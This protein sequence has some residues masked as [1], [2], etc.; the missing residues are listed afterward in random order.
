MATILVAEDERELREHLRDELGER[1]HHVVMASDGLEA[2]AA[3][4]T[5]DLDL[6]IADTRI[7]GFDSAQVRAWK[8][9]VPD[10]EV[11]VAT[12]Q[13]EIANAIDCI[14]AGAFDY[15]EK[16]FAIQTLITTLERALERRQLRAAGMLYEASRVILATREPSRLPEVI[17]NV[18]L[19][20]MS[21]DDVALLVPGDDGKL[22]LACSTA[23]TDSIRREVHT[24]MNA[25]VAQLAPTLREPTILRAG[26]VCSCI[27]FPLYAG[28][29]Q[30]GVLEISRVINPRPFGRSDLEKAAV[31]ASQ[32]LLALENMRLARHAI[33]S[34][35]LAIIGQ[36]ATSIAHEVNNPIAYVLASQTHV[37]EQID[38]TLALAGRLEGGAEVLELRTRLGD[39]RLALED[40]RD[41]AERVRDILRDTRTLAQSHDTAIAADVNES[42]RSALRLVAAELRHRTT[43][44]TAFVD[45]LFVLARPGRLAQVFINVLVHMAEGFGESPTNRITIASRLVNGH[46]VVDLR[47]NGPGIPADKLHRQFDPFFTTNLAIARDIVR[48]RDLR[49]VGRR[50]RDRLHGHAAAR[51]DAAHAYADGHADR[52]ARGAFTDPAHRRRAEH[53][54]GVQA[55]ARC[56]TRARAC[57][58]RRR[59][60]HGDRDAGRLRPGG[61]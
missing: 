56:R 52:H 29:R 4:G 12:L 43:V 7:P 50:R 14:K 18:A 53:S 1:G 34:E 61:L 6:V 5:Y 8:Q 59:S 23:I 31:L 16:P 32:T 40:V 44:T 47:D 58:A 26:N 54:Q 17:V 10:T 28:E 21:A 22:H 48:R 24:T 49:G 19:K 2:L 30:A 37:R 57:G 3:L 60:T 33:S 15:I 36:V 20:A 45:D 46:V 51:G 42:V 27:L 35:R 13:D 39:M 55:R 38:L 11:V 41:G 25:L 9:L